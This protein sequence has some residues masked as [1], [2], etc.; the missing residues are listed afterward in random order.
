MRGPRDAEL[1]RLTLEGS[2]VGMDAAVPVDRVGSV[3]GFVAGATGAGGTL[4][5]PQPAT[6]IARQTAHNSPLMR[7]WR[8]APVLKNETDPFD[9]MPVQR[10][11]KGE[12][13]DSAMNV[14]ARVESK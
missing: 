6:W 8:N 10:E 1:A 7:Q 11:T 5:P 12:V 13:S 3:V 9:D 14:L 4:P 2:A